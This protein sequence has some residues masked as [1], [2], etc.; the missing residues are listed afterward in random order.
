MTTYMRHFVFCM[1]L[2]G[3]MFACV[4]KT[5]QAASAERCFPETGYCISGPIRAYW[6][7]NG[8]LP[9]F[10]FPKGP[11]TTEAVEGVLLTVQWFER[12]RLEI[13]PNGAI[14]AG[15]LGAR[16]LELQQTPWQPGPH[17]GPA[18]GC[19]GFAPTGY[20]VCGEF[21]KYWSKNGGLM[22]F[23]YPITGPFQTTIEG[24]SLIVQ[25]FERRR[26]E[27]HPNN[28]IMLG[29]LGNE[30]KATVQ[31]A[32]PPFPDAASNPW[33][34][35]VSANGT[36][37]IA[38]G[39][40][41]EVRGMNYV[42]ATGV[43]ASKC[44]TL[45]F[46]ADPVCP[47]DQSAIN[48]DFDRLA[49]RGVNTVR[50]FLNYYVFGGAI[51]L[52]DVNGPGI[53]LQHFDALVDAA[54]ARGMYVMPVLLFNY[55]RELLGPAHY[56]H[57]LSTH[58]RPLIWHYAN[59]PGI[60]AWDL[61]NEPDIGSEV[62][63]RCWDWDN[64][65]YPECLP[66]AIERQRFLLAIGADVAANDS[67]HLRTIGMAFAKSYFE[68]AES[69][70]KLAYLVDFYTFHYYDDSPYDSG[71]YK[72]HWYYGR[73]FPHD[74]NRSVQELGVLGL[75]KPVL[76]TEI[77][78]PSKPGEGSRDAASLARDLRTARQTIHNNG[79]SGMVI[80][81]FQDSFDELLGDVYW[82]R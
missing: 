32:I 73:G 12:D 9:V 50:V 78:F 47:W 29:L 82:F 65:D 6:E 62:D 48:A 23:G 52:Y 35:F 45:Q 2:V 22:R 43:D 68:P 28:Q 13:Q 42:R 33:G 26:F 69:P 55:P 3:M 56:E 74:L 31:N 18:A 14:T 7:R 72:A 67:N 49:A 10:G 46:G 54:N 30:V 66:M 20:N 70:I 57:A 39:A 21:A 27:L 77:G 8:G 64:A 76:V 38:G 17:L 4:P 1:I 34:N 60:L 59:R 44:W 16:L 5:M 19:Q 63:L 51:P 15:R 71:R 24:K 61:F 80:W 53:A 41:F 81:S 40:P 37:L 58:V 25:Y 36:Q 79:G 75:N 11:Q